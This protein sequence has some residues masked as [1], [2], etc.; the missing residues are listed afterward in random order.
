MLGRSWLLALTGRAP[1]AV[2]VIT[3]GIAASR[4]MGATPGTPTRSLLPASAVTM[5]CLCPLNSSLW[6]RHGHTGLRRG[7]GG[8]GSRPAPN[9][10]ASVEPRRLQA[11][12]RGARCRRRREIRQDR[13][14]RRLRAG[15]LNGKSPFDFI[16]RCRCLDQSE[17][18]MACRRPTCKP[19]I[20][21]EGALCP[22]T[23]WR[24]LCPRT[25]W[26]CRS[27]QLTL[28]T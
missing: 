16:P 12:P 26:T 1:D 7:G 27:R 17:G 24:R 4:S 19:A 25:I 22:R 21:T 23:L 11:P 8:E 9:R 18:S 6:A 14:S 5:S 13:H 2:Q 10:P 20:Y 15:H 3:S 28:S